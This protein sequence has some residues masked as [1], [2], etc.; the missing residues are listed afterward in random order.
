MLKSKTQEQF[1]LPEPKAE[2][3][4]FKEAYFFASN[5]INYI[6]FLHRVIKFVSIATPI[7]M[8]DLQR[9]IVKCLFD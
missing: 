5:W 7:D 4:E 1:Q 8:Q 9:N 3:G 2:D 6:K